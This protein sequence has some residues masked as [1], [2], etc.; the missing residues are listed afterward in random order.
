MGVRS[1]TLKP[2]SSVILASWSWNT[3]AFT[4]AE[5]VLSDLSVPMTFEDGIS[6]G[7]LSAASD[8]KRFTLT[9]NGFEPSE[10]TERVVTHPDAPAGTLMQ[11]AASFTAMPLDNPDLPNTS[12]D[13][14]YFS[15]NVAGD[16][17]AYPGD[18]SEPDIFGTTGKGVVLTQGAS[19]TGV[20]NADNI[21]ATGLVAGDRVRVSAMLRIDAASGGT[22][23]LGLTGGITAAF[24]FAH[25]ADGK[26]TSFTEAWGT[27][28]TGFYNFPFLINGEQFV[29][30]WVERVA[31]NTTDI[32]FRIQFIDTVS[33]RK[34][35]LCSVAIQK[36]PLD[37]PAAVPVTQSGSYGA[38]QVLTGI[39]S[40]IGYV[41]RGVEA[42]RSMAPSGVIT[43]PALEIGQPYLPVCTQID[44]IASEE[45]A[46]RAG[47]MPNE[48]L[49][50]Y[51]TPW[52]APVNFVRNYGPGRFSRNWL[53]SAS[54]KGC[55]NATIGSVFRRR[56]DKRAKL[57]RISLSRTFLTGKLT[58]DD[59]ILLA[60]PDSRVTSYWEQNSNRSSGAGT[61]DFQVGSGGVSQKNCLVIGS[62]LD[63]TRARYQVQQ[64]RS[65]SKQVFV[66]EWL[67]Q[68][69]G[70]AID[71]SGSRYQYI[72]RRNPGGQVAATVYSVVSDDVMVL[73]CWSDPMIRGAGTYSFA[74]NRNFYGHTTSY[75]DLYLAQSQRQIQVSFDGGTSWENFLD[76]GLEISDLP[77]GAQA[78]YV[79]T[80]NPGTGAVAYGSASD[81]GPL[82]FRY[83]EAGSVTGFVNRIG[84]Q[85]H[86]SQMDMGTHTRY[87]LDNDVFRTAELTGPTGIT[88]MLEHVY[89]SGRWND[90]STW[91]PW[92]GGSAGNPSQGATGTHPD[93]DQITRFDAIITSSQCVGNVMIGK[94][95][96]LFYTGASSLASNG[97][98]LTGFVDDDWIFVGEAIRAVS[99]DWSL[100]TPSEMEIPA[101]LVIQAEQAK[102]FRFVNGSAG[103]VQ[104][105]TAGPNNILTFGSNVVIATSAGS[106]GGPTNGASIVGTA[107]LLPLSV[108]SNFTTYTPAANTL[109][110]DLV[111]NEWRKT[112]DRIRLPES[113]DEARAFRFRADL[114][115]RPGLLANT[116][117]ETALGDH[118]KWDDIVLD[119]RS[120]Y[121]G[122]PDVLVET[123]N[124]VAVGT[125]LA[126]GLS[127]TGF[128]YGEGG[129]EV[130]GLFEIVG[131]E[132]R[133]AK[134]LTGLNRIDQLLSNAGEQIVIDMRPAVA[135]SIAGARIL[136]AAENGET[137][138]VRWVARGLP[139]PGAASLQWQKNG[140]NISGQTAATITLDQTA[141]SLADGDVI[142]CEISVTSA[143][144]SATA[145]PSVSYAAAE[146]PA[147]TASS[148]SGSP[149][150]GQVMTASATVTG[151]PTPTLSYQWQRNGTNISGATASTL[152]LDAATQG[153]VAGD[154]ISCEI[155]ATNASGSATAEPTRTIE[156]DPVAQI[157]AITSGKTGSGTWDFRDATN[158]GTLT[159][160][161]LGGT[162]GNFTQATA[163]N[164][165]A[166][167]TV[168]GLTFDSNDQVGATISNS[169]PYS[170]FILM[171]KD[172]ASN[173]GRILPAHIIY[174][175]GSALSLFITG[176]GVASVDGT[177]VAG[178]PQTRD[179]L[180][181]ALDDDAW[182]IFSVTGLSPGATFDIGRA[183][184]AAMV[185][186]V[187]AAVALRESEFA[188]I[189]AT[190]AAVLAELERLRP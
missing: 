156:T 168:T 45:I 28:R 94:A 129:N 178:S 7:L 86:M 135:P 154:T 167:S 69:T 110:R 60:G 18:H 145:E 16:S 31:T 63:V 169:Q 84:Y 97:S 151:T 3:P 10:G 56:L 19:G 177:A 166:I 21:K 122:A 30:L 142:S 147:F 99:W 38:D 163:A 112:G 182:H 108:V 68:V 77:H 87:P 89:Q 40:Q 114:Q 36:N 65:W 13:P 76:T 47:I 117:I 8:P 185:G 128:A 100:A 90:E 41:L 22:I 150:D 113:S 132:L 107:T 159:A 37:A 127:G 15:K 25:D 188:D 74:R 180:H 82:R 119:L 46:D 139:A 118:D 137:L 102:P 59:N 75:H 24:N 183:A 51:S 61:F 42:A 6:A 138:E 66:G 81:K 149:F 164:Q 96:G 71:D 121:L 14:V 189:A 131:G 33:G 92:T 158:T 179:A 35:H 85:I 53:I 162:A 29:F 190:R 4:F 39:T 152:T 49:L 62:T 11:P 186:N 136:G 91:A 54:S 70:G 64:D 125:V 43:A 79:G 67:P 141:M 115:I 5:V 101:A 52:L 120:K 130:D 146:A 109:A 116:V 134:L 157:A 184:G 48:N 23:G 20:F 140:T 105:L 98:S 165:P 58:I 44:V 55:T 32:N 187:M 12:A 34:L 106:S 73:D 78:T 170:L 50:Y 111:P 181:D 104:M 124:N 9:A 153:W 83:Y 57:G 88:M 143:A 103:S 173:D 155:T 26:I 1:F 27:W 123:P 93:F 17:I 160:T 161:N 133:T 176:S 72:S 80:Y 2:L 171:K 126:S 144:G 148:I 175:N 172:P 174:G 95:Q